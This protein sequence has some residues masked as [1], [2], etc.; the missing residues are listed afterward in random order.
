MLAE[1]APELP[2][3]S[4]INFGLYS[5]PQLRLQV[6]PPSAVNPEADLTAMALGQA[7]LRVSPLQMALAY[8]ALSAGGTRPAP[9]ITLAVNTPQNGWVVLPS[10]DSSHNATNEFAANAT[11]GQLAAPEALF[12]QTTARAL[13]GDKTIVWYLAGTL[14]SWSGSPLTLVVLLEED[15]PAAVQQIGSALMQQALALP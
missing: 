3:T 9:R 10:L 12:W 5:D 8:A 4:L 7:E 6:A 2:I 11:A 13:N 1:S 14:P 15:D